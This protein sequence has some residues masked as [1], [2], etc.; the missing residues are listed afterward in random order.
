MT[1]IV[2]LICF[3]ITSADSATFVLAML[4]S[5]GDMDPPDNKKVFWGILIALIALALIL[6]GGVAAIQ[7][8][9]IVIAFPY[10]FILLLLCAT[11]VKEFRKI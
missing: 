9:S 2:L 1:A 8:V 11:L 6:S 3:F 4:T 7:T 5:D 10:L